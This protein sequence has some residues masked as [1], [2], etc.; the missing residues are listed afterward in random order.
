MEYVISTRNLTRQFGDFTAVDNVSINVKRGEIYG[1]LGPN[2]AGKT[3]LIKML[4]GILAPTSG[5]A[6]ILGFDL[7]KDTDAIKQKIGYMSQKYSLY[8]DL[9]VMENLEFYAGVYEIPL[10][11]K[12][13][14]ICQMIEMA[15]LSGREN[16]LASNLST[17][18]KQRLA[19]GCSIISRPSVI[20]L[21][22][23]TSGV[24]PGS[25]RMFFE[26]INNLASSGITVIVT[27][28]F[29]DEAE[30][31]SKLMFISG[32]KLV[33]ADTPSNL[34]KN[35]MHGILVELSLPDAIDQIN[36]IE[37]LS[38]V[39]ECNIHGAFLHVVVEN[40]S[41]VGALESFSG[42]HAK[43]IT[44]SLED[45]FLALSKQH[46]KEGDANEQN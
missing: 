25:R 1:F 27:T 32:G 17:G 40:K 2:G 24:S 41:C 11:E 28:H 19:L 46:K 12:K 5:S 13:G 43:I 8:D 21:D 20:F 36:K 33:A 29:M 34:K 10:N 9:T 39:K 7:I 35:A 45:V 44:P 37:R 16:D 30:R 18:F 3:T 4:C 31:C 22:E 42:G 14:R 26:I 15:G 23:P 6:Q 38:Y